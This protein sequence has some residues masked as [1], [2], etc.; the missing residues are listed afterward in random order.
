L[1]V[2]KA[3][4]LEQRQK[5]ES[6]LSNYSIPLQILQMV[7]E[8]SQCDAISPETRLKGSGRNAKN[9]HILAALNDKSILLLQQIFLECHDSFS[10]FRLAVY[11]SSQWS[12]M[13]YKFIMGEVTHGKSRRGYT[14]DVCVHDRETEEL[15]AVG[16]QNNNAGHKASDNESLHRF[17]DAISDLYAEHP[18]L[19]RAYYASSYG[20]KD[21]DPSRVVKRGRAKVE[22]GDIEITLLEYKNTAYFENKS[23]SSD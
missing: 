15:V 11:L 4:T 21:K 2:E 20:Y 10:N 1:Q 13:R 7:A 23:I 3:L 8:D 16:M 14:C 18:R 17:L 5:I 6:R 19:H 22:C 12:T 9:S